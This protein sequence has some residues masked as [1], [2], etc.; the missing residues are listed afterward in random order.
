M[1]GQ[2]PFERL[3]NN[4]ALAQRFSKR[5]AFEKVIVCEDEPARFAVQSDRLFQNFGAIVIGRRISRLIGRKIQHID[6]GETP[7]LIFACRVR[8]Q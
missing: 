6:I 8:K 3:K 1:L 2:R 5:V 4:A 7:R